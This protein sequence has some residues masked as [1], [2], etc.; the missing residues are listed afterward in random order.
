MS[1]DLAIGILISAAVI[2]VAKEIIDF[3]IKHKK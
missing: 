2:I 1:Q 3:V